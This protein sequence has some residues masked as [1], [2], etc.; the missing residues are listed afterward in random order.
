MRRGSY[1]SEVARISLAGRVLSSWARYMQRPPVP[2]NPMRIRSFASRTRWLASSVPV[3]AVV[4]NSLRFTGVKYHKWRRRKASPV[5]VQKERMV[6]NGCMG[7]D[8]IAGGERDTRRGG[9]TGG[10][11]VL[12]SQ[13]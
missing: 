8:G 12:A 7:D 3:A 4:T 5:C 6:W 10:Q 9:E 11:H 13:R 2:I 1:A